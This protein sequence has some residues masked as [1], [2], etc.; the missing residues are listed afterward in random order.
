MAARACAHGDDAVDALRRGLFG[1]T[2][3]D[4]VVKDNAA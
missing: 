3:V 1:M 2:Q 4:D